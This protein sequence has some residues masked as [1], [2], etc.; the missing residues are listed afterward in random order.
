[1]KQ[2]PAVGVGVTIYNNKNQML[3]GKR[4]NSH[5]AGSWCHP[6]GHLE[7]GETFEQC[8]IREVEEETGLKVSDPKFVS[9]ATECFE[10]EQK[11][12][13]SVFMRV[14]M[15]EGQSVQ[16]IEPD[17]MEEWKWF[18]MDNLP[19]NLFLPFQKLLDGKVHGPGL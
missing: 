14:G 4:K 19:D 16:N 5:G 2:R 6:G 11:S 9:V 10:E 17:K 13:V 18:D 3:F 15:P 1:M 12:F 8:A 7:F